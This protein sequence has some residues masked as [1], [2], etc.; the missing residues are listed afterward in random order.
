MAK[1]EAHRLLDS[2]EEGHPRTTIYGGNE[3]NPW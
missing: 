1:G 2:V 3:E